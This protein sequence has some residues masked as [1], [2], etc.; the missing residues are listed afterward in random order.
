MF[1]GVGQRKL[2]AGASIDKVFNV[3]EKGVAGDELTDFF[4]KDDFTP[5]VSGNE[6]SRIE[7]PRSFMVYES[8]NEDGV[9]HGVMSSGKEDLIFVWF[10]SSGDSGDGDLDGSK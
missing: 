2:V 7:K 5:F 8:G 6:V 10:E 1:N 3:L 9:S 4:S